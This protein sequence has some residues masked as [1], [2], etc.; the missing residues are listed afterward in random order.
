MSELVI[1]IPAAFSRFSQSFNSLS[2]QFAAGESASSSA[3]KVELTKLHV[4]MRDKSRR[5]VWSILLS[6]ST[7]GDVVEHVHSSSY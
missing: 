5:S 7:V 1:L 3:Q 4:D 6:F 2:I